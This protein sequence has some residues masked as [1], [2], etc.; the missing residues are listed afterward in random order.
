MLLICF[1]IGVSSKCVYN[2]C[3]ILLL[4]ETQR[5]RY[6]KYVLAASLAERFLIFDY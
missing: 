5:H 4:I 3:D 2:L 6:L 1:A